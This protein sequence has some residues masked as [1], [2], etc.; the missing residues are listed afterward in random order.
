VPELIVIN[1]ADVADPLVVSRLLAREPH[2]VVASARTGAGIDELLAAIE[3]DLPRPAVELEVLLP[4][5]RGDLLNKMHEY[6]EV[7]S[8]DH[9]EDGS[10]VV[11]RVNPSLA[12]ELEPFVAAR[13]T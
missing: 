4:Y 3:R 9:T 13:T 8:V 2:A 6:G 5:R 7:V 1:K 10:R 12:G 11:A